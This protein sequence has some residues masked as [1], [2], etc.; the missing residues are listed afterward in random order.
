MKDYSW[1]LEE[2]VELTAEELEWEHRM[3]ISASIYK[4]MQ[5]LNVSEQELAKRMGV[6]KSQVSRLLTCKR[7]ITLA[8][9]ARVEEALDFRL[10][11]GFRY[12]A[13]Q[14]T[15]SFSIFRDM[16]INA[17]GG[18]DRLNWENV[19]TTQTKFESSSIKRE[20]LEAA[21]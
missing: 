3:D 12:Y 6:N 14:T 7:N 20:K 18:C 1:V 21:A 19:R 15:A 13:I 8:V 4:R 5:E 2:K 16:R 17:P 10:D 9:L 11:D